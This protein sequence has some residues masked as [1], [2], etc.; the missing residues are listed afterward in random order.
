MPGLGLGAVFFG[1]CGT[2]ARE[3]CLRARKEDVERDCLT[4]CLGMPPGT[5]SVKKDTQKLRE[6][7]GIVRQ[8]VFDAVDVNEIPRGRKPLKVGNALV[9]GVPVV[10][11]VRRELES[12]GHSGVKGRAVDALRAEDGTDKPVRGRGR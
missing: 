2:D 11:V 5:M 1:D 8:Q 7:V 9:H 3:T 6:A 10:T 4:A 12:R